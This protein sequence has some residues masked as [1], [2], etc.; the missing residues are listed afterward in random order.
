VIPLT[1]DNFEW[2]EDENGDWY[3]RSKTD[4]N[5]E[6]YHW[7]QEEKQSEQSDSTSVNVELKVVSEPSVYCKGM[8]WDDMLLNIKYLK[9]DAK[10]LTITLNEGVSKILEL[11]SGDHALTR[12]NRIQIYPDI[13][14]KN[15]EKFLQK[16]KYKTNGRITYDDIWMIIDEST[17]KNGSSG[18]L[19]TSQG[20]FIR[21]L[22]RRAFVPW[23]VEDKWVS[24]FYE[25]KGFL[26]RKLFATLSDSTNLVILE[27]VEET[28]KKSIQEVTGYLTL[29]ADLARKE[30]CNQ[31]G[32]KYTFV[33]DGVEEAYSQMVSG[34]EESTPENSILSGME[35]LQGDCPNC[36]GMMRDASLAARGGKALLRGFAKLDRSMVS[37]STNSN[38]RSAFG[39]GGGWFDNKT[40]DK[41]RVCDSCGYKE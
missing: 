33:Y 38:L 3:Y 22:G 14:R 39:S 31:N 16:N 8:D 10:L 19:V 40:A 37:K 35:M 41:S 26:F 21:S 4:P 30:Y 36:G 12:K 27:T 29:I 6:W 15:V 1:D 7:E 24:S 17:F 18:M 9:K 2:W 28:L 34:L 13:K 20:L 11:A 5:G 25:E 23:M 32:L